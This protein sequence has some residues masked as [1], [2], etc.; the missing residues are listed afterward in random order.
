VQSS[1]LIKIK[2]KDVREFDKYDSTTLAAVNV[3]MKAKLSQKCAV[4]LHNRATSFSARSLTVM[5]PFKISILHRKTSPKRSTT[6]VHYT[7]GAPLVQAVIVFCNIRAP[8]QYKVVHGYIHGACHLKSL[9]TPQEMNHLI[10]P[11]DR[12]ILFICIQDA[13]LQQRKKQVRAS[14]QRR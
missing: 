13:A 1:L 9:S 4:V 12:S 8:T 11:I 7:C 2:I 3:C 5:F 10:D 6:W 14:T